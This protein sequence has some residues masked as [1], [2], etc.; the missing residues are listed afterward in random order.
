MK[1][2]SQAKEKNNLEKEKEK[3]KGRRATLQSSATTRA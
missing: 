2:F 1:R 3:E